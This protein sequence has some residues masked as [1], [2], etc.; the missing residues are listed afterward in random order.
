MSDT[1]QNEQPEQ[2]IEL[3]LDDDDNNPG[4][5]LPGIVHAVV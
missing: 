2:N 5:P 4:Q 1:E 3:Q